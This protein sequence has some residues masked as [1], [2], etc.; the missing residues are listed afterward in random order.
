MM[1]EWMVTIKLSGDGNMAVPSV[2]VGGAKQ[3]ETKRKF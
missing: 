2:A 3:T 1:Q